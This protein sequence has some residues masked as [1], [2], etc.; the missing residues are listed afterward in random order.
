MLARAALPAIVGPKALVLRF[1]GQY[2]HAYE[3]CRDSGRAQHLEAV[4]RQL[5]GQ[6]WALRFELD[7]SA[8]ATEPAAPPMSTRDR[9]RQALESPLL[10]RIVS[11]LDGRL[12]KLDE[13][14]GGNSPEDE[15]VEVEEPAA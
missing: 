15:P 6:E 1:P 5:T 14:F 13:E 3:Y 9:E 7:A 4:L 12:L 10:S 2:N 11:Q 8:A